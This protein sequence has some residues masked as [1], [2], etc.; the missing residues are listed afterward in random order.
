MNEDEGGFGGENDPGKPSV[1]L[2]SHPLSV[3]I[4][5]A[6]SSGFNRIDSADTTACE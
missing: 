3:S 1:G 4:T 2:G 5:Y 6:I